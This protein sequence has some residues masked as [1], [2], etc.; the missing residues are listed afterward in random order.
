MLAGTAIAAPGCLALMAAAT[1]S[2]GPALREEI[3][4]LA[5]CSA[6]RSAMALPIPR[7]DPVITATLPV[8]SNNSPMALPSKHVFDFMAAICGAGRRWVKP[9]LGAISMP[10]FREIELPEFTLRAATL[11]EGPL[12]LMVHGFPE[13]WY[14]WRHQMGP[15]AAAGFTACA[16]DVRGY[17]GSSRPQPIEAYDMEHLVADVAGVIEQLSPDT[18]AVLLGH[19]CGAPILWDT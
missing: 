13:S 1:S 15:V 6:M 5:P 7:E 12:V 14:S 11:G 10:D 2:Q 18:P 4:T 16:I 8:R 17:G 9:G 19:D 3:V